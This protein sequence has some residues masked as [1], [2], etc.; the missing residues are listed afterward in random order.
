VVH[1]QRGDEVVAVVVNGMPPQ[2]QR[3]A[4]R[5]WLLA[6][7]SYPEVTL[8]AVR[9]KAAEAKKLLGTGVDPGEA[10]KAEKAGRLLLA[11]NSFEAIARECSRPC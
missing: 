10:R 9:E 7:G 11:A 8:K 1:D 5:E 6:L 4:S 3:L 2:R